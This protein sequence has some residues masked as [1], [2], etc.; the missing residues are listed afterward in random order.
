MLEKIPYRE[1]WNCLREEWGFRISGDVIRDNTP[2]GETTLF[3]CGNCDL[4][5]FEP[6]VPGNAEF[7]RE[8][9]E[10]P[11]YYSPW[12]WEF[13]WTMSRLASSSEVLDVGCGRGDFLSAVAPNVR[14]AVGLDGN[15]TAVLQARDR[16]L[17]V[18]A[19]ELSTHAEAF[20]G[21]F[22]AV[23]A[24][25]VLEHLSDPV[26][27]IGSLRR[28]LHP[29][30]SLFLSVPNRM[31]S[32]RAAAEPLDSPPHH[33]TR[34]SPRS[35]ERLADACGLR[36]RDIA[37]EPVELSVPRDRL[38]ERVR[39]AV[40]GIPVVGGFLGTMAPALAWRILLPESLAPLYRRLGVFERSGMVGMSVAARFTEPS[41]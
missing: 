14:R 4:Q 41:P 38:R 27:F 16:G 20:E 36:L 40:S 19:G 11:R 31:R 32:A 37:L 7:Y 13:G 21:T 6:A 17:E 25:H 9:G 18:F 2:C 39:S 3:E 26:R 22:S 23:C 29:G 1:I 30:G 35:L 28:C 10:N 15:T 34:W 33:L 12:K 24:F 5:F 8:L